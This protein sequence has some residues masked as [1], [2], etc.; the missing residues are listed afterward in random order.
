M[1]ELDTILQPETFRFNPQAPAWAFFPN[2]RLLLG[3]GE[4]LWET[5]DER[6]SAA[7]TVIMY[8]EHPQATMPAGMDE[9]IKWREDYDASRPPMPF[10]ARGMTAVGCVR[11]AANVVCQA[12]GGPADCPLSGCHHPLEANQEYR[13]ARLVGVDGAV[14]ITIEKRIKSLNL[15]HRTKMAELGLAHERGT[16]KRALR[17]QLGEKRARRRRNPNEQ[18]FAEQMSKMKEAYRARR[19]DELHTDLSSWPPE[20]LVE[21]ARQERYRLELVAQ[22]FNNEEG[23]PHRAFT[24]EELLL[25][26]AK[27]VADTEATALAHDF[28]WK[29]VVSFGA[30]GLHAL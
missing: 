22:R 21:M 12:Y 17:K 1:A 20:F 24:A 13:V 27:A 29:P 4:G 15:E 7:R 30:A 2:L 6:L 9:F 26:T 18:A 10:Y 5:L 16:G 11:I 25:A 14:T 28:T 3:W 23:E 19:I 8:G